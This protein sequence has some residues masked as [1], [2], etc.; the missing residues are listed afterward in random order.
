MTVLKI[1]ITVLILNSMVNSK[2]M[3]MMIQ[4]SSEKIMMQV[5]MRNLKRTELPIV[6]T[7]SMMLR[8]TKIMKILMTQ[9]KRARMK[10]LQTRMLKTLIDL[11]KSLMMRILMSLTNSMNLKSLTTKLV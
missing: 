2:M 4:T 5:E 7:S 1:L 8:M 10:S 11:M 6:A 3:L 9:M